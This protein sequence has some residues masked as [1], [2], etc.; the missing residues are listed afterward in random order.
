M[1]NAAP[2][3]PD[4]VRSELAV[5]RAEEERLGQRI[6]R[7]AVVSAKVSISHNPHLKA[8]TYFAQW[9]NDQ[10]IQTTEWQF[11]TARE[12]AVRKARKL[13]AWFAPHVDVTLNGLTR[14]ELATTEVQP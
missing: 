11:Y 2:H 5:L 10:G 1:P 4:E 13:L 14:A 3:V 12:G 8:A 7:L 9:V 6:H